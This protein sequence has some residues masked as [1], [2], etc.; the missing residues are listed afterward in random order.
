VKL[1]VERNSSVFVLPERDVE[2]LYP[3]ERGGESRG[4]NESRERRAH[5]KALSSGT[6][7]EVVKNTL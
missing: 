1:E 7:E 6:L 5:L 4:M 3:T 2:V